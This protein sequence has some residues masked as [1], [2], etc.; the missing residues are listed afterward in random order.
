MG[1]PPTDGPWGE[2]RYT[3]GWAPIVITIKTN[4]TDDMNMTPHIMMIGTMDDKQN[5]FIIWSLF[6]DSTFSINLELNKCYSTYNI[7]YIYI[8]IYIYRIYTHVYLHIYEYIHIYTYI[9]TSAGVPSPVP[10][11][12]FTMAAAAGPPPYGPSMRPQVP[13]RATPAQPRSVVVVSGPHCLGKGTLENWAAL[14]LSVLA[15]P[16]MVRICT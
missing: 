15:G 5:T 9:R 11:L 8:Y 3:S 13:P 1:R 12:G 16:A 7:L 4:N 10:H 14:L 2:T 6:W